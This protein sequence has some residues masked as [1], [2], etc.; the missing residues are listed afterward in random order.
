MVQGYY[1]ASSQEAS[2]IDIAKAAG[3]ILKSHGII[4]SG[5]PRAI[6]LE[7]VDATMG[8]YGYPHIGTYMFAANSRTRAHR[9]AKLLGYKPS[10]PSLWDTMEADLLA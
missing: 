6:S 3:T 7:E 5:E 2:Q 10:A 8:D 4:E 9:A 1:F